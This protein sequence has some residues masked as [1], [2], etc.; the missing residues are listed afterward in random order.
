MYS[1]NTVTRPVNI[2]FYDFA[3]VT[4]SVT[5]VT[6]LAGRMVRLGWDNARARHAGWTG[7]N[8]IT[9]QCSQGFSR[10]FQGVTDL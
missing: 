6:G 7:C 2:G 3:S 8:V 4:G 1:R 9:N 10:D 5:G